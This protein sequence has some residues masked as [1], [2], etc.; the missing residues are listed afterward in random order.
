ML[1]RNLLKSL[2]SFAFAPFIA[3][4][5]DE[6][7]TVTLIDIKTQY[8]TEYTYD[9]NNFVVKRKLFNV[10]ILKNGQHVINDDKWVEKYYDKKGN[11]KKIKYSSGCWEKFTFNDDN[12]VLTKIDDQGNYKEYQYNDDKLYKL[13]IEKYPQQNKTFTTYYDNR[14]LFTRIVES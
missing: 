12:M 13:V 7:K 8:K 5:E 3:K 11:I 14:G 10:I 9:K 1:R 6:F 2:T 4:K